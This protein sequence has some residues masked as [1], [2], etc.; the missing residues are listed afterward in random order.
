MSQTPYRAF[1]GDRALEDLE[2]T[3]DY[4]FNESQSKETA[5]AWLEGVIDSKEVLADMPY[6]FGFAREDGVLPRTP[7]RQLIYGSYRL[8]YSVD[9]DAR[10]VRILRVRH[11]AMRPAT[12]RDLEP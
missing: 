6:G 3:F 7:L 12:R 1:F 5:T 11:A 8:I 10:R 4:I 9:D 2:T